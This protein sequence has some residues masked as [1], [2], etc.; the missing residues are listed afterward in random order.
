M[1]CVARSSVAYSC[2]RWEEPRNRRA[3]PKWRRLTANRDEGISSYFFFWLSERASRFVSS[4]R[5]FIFNCEW[6]FFIPTRICLFSLILTRRERDK[7]SKQRCKFR[8]EVLHRPVHPAQ[9]R[10]KVHEQKLVEEEEDKWQVHPLTHAIC[11]NVVVLHERY[12]RTNE[13]ENRI[14]SSGVVKWRKVHQ[15]SASGETRVE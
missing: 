1:L 13:H 14:E 5:H 10:Y 8:R 11:A 4:R 3:T 2:V 9:Y 6:H 12:E 15:L 7:M